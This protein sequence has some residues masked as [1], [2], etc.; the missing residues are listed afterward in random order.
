MTFNELDDGSS[1]ASMELYE[2]LKQGPIPA[3]IPVVFFRSVPARR[4]NVPAC[5]RTERP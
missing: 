5:R 1:A 2:T 3:C 4:W